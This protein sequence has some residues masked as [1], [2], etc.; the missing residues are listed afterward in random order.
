M[1]LVAAQVDYGPSERGRKVENL[2]PIEKEM[3]KRGPNE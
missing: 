3:A 1:V 2:D